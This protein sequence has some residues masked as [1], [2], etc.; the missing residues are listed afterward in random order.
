MLRVG[1]RAEAQV[2]LARIVAV[3]SCRPDELAGAKDVLR[4]FPKPAEPTVLVELDARWTRAGSTAG[5]CA[6]RASRSPPTSANA[7]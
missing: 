1:L 2:P 5:R 7:S 4:A 3:R 6:C